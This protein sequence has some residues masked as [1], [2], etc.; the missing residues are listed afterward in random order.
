MKTSETGVTEGFTLIELLVVLLVIGVLLGLLL[1]A[2]QQSREASRR[3]ACTNHLKQIGVAL[4]N[5]HA[6]FSR[7]PAGIKPDGFTPRGLPFAVPSPVSIHVQIL[8]FLD[9]GVLYNGMNLFNGRAFSRSS[10]PEALGSMNT[11]VSKAA[12]ETFLCPS[13]YALRPGNSYR[14]TVGPHP[15]LHDG[16]TWPGGGGVFPGLIATSDRDIVDGLSNTV[17]FSERLNGGGGEGGFSAVRD[18]WCSGV[19]NLGVPVD[20][21]EMASVCASGARSPSSFISDLGSFWTVGGYANTLY[22]HVTVPN[23]ASPDC[24]VASGDPDP[25]G[26]GIVPGGSLSARSAHP[27]GVNVLLMDG[28]VRFIS[29]TIR[30]GIWRALSTRSG[31]EPISASD[32]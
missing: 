17:G 27:G 2:V 8:P 5:S 14:G 9:Q 13:D 31:H 1:P 20:S 30:V 11:T 23:W 28:S 25:A 6:V 16:T 21:D 32:Y 12:V 26:G 19:A 15:S 24:S 10:P 29:Q 7:Y 18:A 3:L 22:N 4:A